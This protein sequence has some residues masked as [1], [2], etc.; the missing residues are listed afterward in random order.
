LGAN[1]SYQVEGAGLAD[2][3]ALRALE[4]VCF[5]GDAWPWFDLV[6][7]LLMPGL[8][9]LK[10]SVQGR[11]VGFVGG[12]PHPAEGVGW[13]ATLGVL[14]EYRRLGIATTLLLAC[15]ERMGLGVVRLSVRRSNQSAIDLYH[16]EGYRLVDIWASYYFDQEDA[17]VLEKKR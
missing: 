14:P 2:F 11:M 17:L 1:G 7:V 16:K 12:D 6:G 9:R 5:G 4:Q 13:I 8:V 3:N 15:E 10:A